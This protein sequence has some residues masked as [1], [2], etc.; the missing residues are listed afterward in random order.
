MK[1]SKEININGKPLDEMLADHKIWIETNCKEGHKAQLKGVDLRNID[2]VGIDLRGANL[3]GV[4]L[5]KV[6]LTRTKLSKANLNRSNLCEVDLRRAVLCGAHFRGAILVESIL[7][8]ADLYQVDFYN[9]ELASAD[10]SGAN[11]TSANLCKANLYKA[12]LLKSNLSRAVLTEADLRMANLCGANLNEAILNNADLTESNLSDAD[13]ANAKFTGTIF[14]RVVT[15]EW[16][17]EGIKCDFIFLNSDKNER[18]P[19]ERD[20]ECSEFEALYKSVPTFE[21]IFEKGMTWR[22]AIV[23][24]YVSTNLQH[25]FPGL[26][27]VTLDSK[28]RDP[29]AIFEIFSKEMAGKAEKTIRKDFET[30]ISR[31]ETEKALLLDLVEKRLLQPNCTN[32]YQA[33]VSQVNQNTI[34][35]GQLASHI[36]NIY[37]IIESEPEASFK[38]N[39]K[40]TIQ[41]HLKQIRKYIE[42]GAFKEAGKQMMDWGIDKLG[43]AIPKVAPIIGQLM[44]GFLSNGTGPVF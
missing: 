13:L 33:P 23:M 35:V 8:K 39:D 16:K 12:K 9:A 29:K 17:I 30:L 31:L 15:F 7:R 28:G 26:K 3:E 1:S 10:L 5:Q 21:F 42:E 32:I 41:A 36:D 4:D 44:R 22:D 38:E 14:N 27:L 19:K 37:K 43:E 11:L 40:K 18:Y 20:F 34:F 6:D 24:D 25:E 2:L